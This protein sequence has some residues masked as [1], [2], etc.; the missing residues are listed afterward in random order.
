MLRPTSADFLIASTGAMQEQPVQCDGFGLEG[1]ELDLGELAFLDFAPTIDAG[2]GF[3]SFTAVQATQELVGVVAR[4][5]LAVRG[6][7][8]GFDGVAAQKFAP[9]VI[10]E[11]AGGEDVAPGDI[12]AIGHHNA[13]DTLTL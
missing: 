12:A 4:G 11:I 5:G 2:L 3:L 13:D 9:V 6:T 8:E 1:I 10:E 7:G